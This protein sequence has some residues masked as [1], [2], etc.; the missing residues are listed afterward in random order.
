MW[1]FGTNI[2]NVEGRTWTSVI[3]IRSINV[4]YGSGV[5]NLV[6]GK[7]GRWAKETCLPGVAQSTTLFAGEE[8]LYA[9]DILG[10]LSTDGR[11]RGEAR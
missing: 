6:G 4:F 10:D 3:I 8:I 9:G 5:M 11:R 1:Q 2:G 7:V